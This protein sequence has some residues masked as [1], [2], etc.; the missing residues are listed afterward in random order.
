VLLIVAGTHLGRILELSDQK[1][2]GFLVLIAFKRLFP[3]HVCKLFDEMP[4][5]I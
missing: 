4:V 1:T 5:R 3:E 2:Q